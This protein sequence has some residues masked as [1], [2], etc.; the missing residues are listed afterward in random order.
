MVVGGGVRTL[1]TSYRAPKSCLV[2]S[3]LVW[4]G[5]CR[6]IIFSIDS[7]LPL[8]ACFIFLLS[9][10]TKNALAGCKVNTR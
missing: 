9:Y 6:L 5:I 8:E 3:R 4:V 7:V 1:D 10:K 2:G